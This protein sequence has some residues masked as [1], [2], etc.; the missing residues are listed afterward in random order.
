MHMGYA[1]SRRRVEERLMEGIVAI[2]LTFL[3]TSIGG[4]WWAAKLQERS[5]VRQNDV[6][7]REAESE[8][9]S[10]TCSN[11]MSLLDRRLYRMQRLLWGGHNRS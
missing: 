7:L 4:A 3:L 10:A 2:V 6:R 1:A 8:R 9:A 11:L 5:W